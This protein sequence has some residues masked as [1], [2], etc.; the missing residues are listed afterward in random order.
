VGRMEIGVAYSAGLGFHQD[1]A[2][3]G[4]WNV[5]FQELQWFPELLNNRCVHLGGHGYLLYDFFNSLGA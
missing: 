5:P 2:G 3:A 4:R 1:L